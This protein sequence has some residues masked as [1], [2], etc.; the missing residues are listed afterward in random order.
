VVVLRPKTGTAVALLALALALAPAALAQDCPRT[1]LAD[2]EDEVMC[3]ACGIPLELA[4]DAPQA[5]REREFIVGLVDS[6]ASKDQVKSALVAEFGEG[7]LAVPDDEG[8]DL[9]AYVVPALAV[10]LGLG[11]VALAVTRWRRRRPSPAPSAGAPPG[12]AEEERLDADLKRYE[13]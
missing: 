11:A 10:L 13:L 1:S 9:A 2:I 4:T 7:V 8:F 5:K 6:C 3:V 12:G